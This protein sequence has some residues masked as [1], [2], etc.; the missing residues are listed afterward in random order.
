MIRASDA[1]SI[2]CWRSRGRAQTRRPEA[3][4]AAAAA[5]AFARLYVLPSRPNALPAEIRLA[6]VW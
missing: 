4:C 2:A 6:P 1:A 3:A 5:L